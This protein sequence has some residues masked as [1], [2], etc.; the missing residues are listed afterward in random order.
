MSRRARHQG[1]LPLCT[2]VKLLSF[3]VA[4][5]L[6]ADSKKQQKEGRNEVL[7]DAI[8]GGE[9]LGLALILGQMVCTSIIYLPALMRRRWNPF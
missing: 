8:I 4:G 2:G 9:A 6:W 7:M 1:A 3:K 5:G